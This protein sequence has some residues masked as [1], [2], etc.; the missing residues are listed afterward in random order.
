MNAGVSS[1]NQE[2]LVL[3]IDVEKENGIL[4]PIG[5]IEISDTERIAQTRQKISQEIDEVF[6][7][8]EF[9]FLYSVR[10]TFLPIG[11]KQEETFLSKRVWPKAIL[12]VVNAP[13][14]SQQPP[15]VINPSPTPYGYSAPGQTIP[16]SYSG[17]AVPY[18]K[19]S[20]DFSNTGAVNVPFHPLHGLMSN[21]LPDALSA[22]EAQRHSLVEGSPG[23]HSF[24]MPPS[25]SLPSAPAES[26]SPLQPGKSILVGWPNEDVS[27][28]RLFAPTALPS[29]EFRPRQVS[30][31]SGH[32]LVAEA[33]GHVFAMGE[34]NMGQLGFR[35]NSLQHS[36]QV[37]V[38]IDMLS[39]V[40]ILQVACG[41]NHSLAR[42]DQGRVF[43]WGSN[44]FGQ[45]GVKRVVEGTGVGAADDQQVI[46][47]VPVEVRFGL[48]ACPPPVTAIGC[49]KDFS[50][51]LNQEG[52]MYIWGAGGHGQLGD[53]KVFNSD[54]PVRVLRDYTVTTFACGY[55][56]ISAATDNR[57]VLSWGRN[58]IEGWITSSLLGFFQLMPTPQ[59]VATVPL[60]VREMAAGGTTDAD[61]HT[62]VLCSDGSV[63]GFGRGAEGQ[64]GPQGRS[65]SDFGYVMSGVEHIACYATY[66]YAFFP[67]GRLHRIND[68]M[69][70]SH[71]VRSISG[72]SKFSVAIFGSEPDIEAQGSTSTTPHAVSNQP[73]D[74]L[75]PVIP[76]SPTSTHPFPTS[77]PNI[78]PPP[79]P[80][81][82]LSDF[83]AEGM[84]VAPLPLPQPQLQ[85]FPSAASASPLSEP[86]PASP[87]EHVSPPSLNP[88][89]STP[90]DHTA[91]VAAATPIAATISLDQRQMLPSADGAVISATVLVQD[92]SLESKAKLDP[93]AV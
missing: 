70:F 73:K 25:S 41:A 72:N 63:Y 6:L 19:N 56:H 57:Q 33:D 4:V 61:G 18:T 23:S 17:F 28:Q 7:P 67:E 74:T 87:H 77:T 16:P 51:A 1:S 60:F 24:P 47:S 89:N 29:T 35:R 58:G 65:R 49:G 75:P 9:R 22:A 20:S 90:R 31:G 48:V 53:G 88:S 32:T 37:P 8:I 52:Q 2:S 21:R 46:V 78:E 12:R 30:C 69:A 26:P 81:T 15:S 40:R 50:A 10:G 27:F 44:E 34:N 83:V 36:L 5:F 39:S 13:L 85:P 11:L 3:E 91:P 66:S 71:P 54:K 38:Y 82:V 62:L 14:L 86:I 76:I 68:G 92:L 93:S 43:A 79:L 80:S 42:T 64:L 59:I 55:E 84:G 45:I